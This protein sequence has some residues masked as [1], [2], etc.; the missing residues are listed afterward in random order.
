MLT[1]LQFA[2]E[3]FTG[4]SSEDRKT[5]RHPDLGYRAES[6]GRRSGRLRRSVRTAPDASPDLRQIFEDLRARLL[7]LELSEPL[8]ARTPE[9]AVTSSVARPEPAVSRAYLTTRGVQLVVQSRLP[10]GPSSHTSGGWIF[11]S[12]QRG[13]KVQLA[14]QVP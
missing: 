9:R 2:M 3:T 4:L 13:A 10:V 12:P 1:M 5:A 14:L 7:A 8:W 6:P 11:L